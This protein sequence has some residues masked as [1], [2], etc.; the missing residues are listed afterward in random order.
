V[1]AFTALAQFGVQPERSWYVGDAGPE[2]SAA[3]EAGFGTIA[4][5]GRPALS[6]RRSTVP[7]V[8]VGRAALLEELVP[9]LAPVLR[10]RAPG[11]P[12]QPVAAV[13]FD[14]GFTLVDHRRSPEDVVRHVAH[15][16]GRTVTLDDVR[17][18]L[19]TCAP[20][21][22]DLR[23]WRSD[24]EIETMLRRFYGQVLARLGVPAEVQEVPAVLSEYTSPGNWRALPGARRALA[25]V[26]GRGLA[27]VV[28]SNWQSGVGSVLAAAG[29]GDDVD[30][31]VASAALGMAKPDPA[32]FAAV[33][34]R[35]GVPV[36]ALTYV[37]DDARSDATAVLNAGG[38]AVL[39]SRCPA[40]DELVG[41][42]R[43]AIG[44]PASGPALERSSPA[45]QPAPSGQ[46]SLPPNPRG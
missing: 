5:Q 6:S 30:H 1:A 9:A 41:S 16:A 45:G 32:C 39:V 3:Q 10:R 17:L 44:A 27:V 29:L 7:D 38:R 18:A 42:V 4:V 25:A 13:A 19:R 21:L 37:G 36:Q 28:F 33:A 23:A 22:S 40:A 24:P 34:A 20:V 2:W 11:E 12:E 14:V 8:V 15:R 46:R 43:L 26:A 35:V 31:V